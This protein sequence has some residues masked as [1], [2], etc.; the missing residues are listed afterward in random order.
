MWSWRTGESGID[1]ID[2]AA[3]GCY[4]PGPVTMGGQAVLGDPRPAPKVGLRFRDTDVKLD[5]IIH[6]TDPDVVFAL[7]WN[8]ADLVV[9]ELTAG[10]VTERIVLLPSDTLAYRVLRRAWNTETVHYLRYERCDAY[11]GYCLFTA[12]LGLDPICNGSCAY[13]GSIG[14][15]VF[16][17]YTKRFTAFVHHAVYHRTPDTHL[18]HGLLTVGIHGYRGDSGGGGGAASLESAVVLLKPCDGHAHSNAAIRPGEPLP[19]PRAITAQGD[20]RLAMPPA[21]DGMHSRPQQLARVAWALATG[22]SGKYGLS[23]LGW[24]DVMTAEWLNGDEKTLIYVTGKE[25]TVW[26]FG[27]DVD[28][29]AEEKRG[30]RLW[31]ERWRRILD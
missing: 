31:G 18:W 5:F 19:V 23:E 24:L 30:K 26:M 25:Y 28:T 22:S 8:E 9:H 15:V 29:K 14:S 4:A 16:N 1:V 11:G 17:I 7:T 12:W 3:Q 20:L 21:D 13:A 27:R 2:A 10:R 6:P